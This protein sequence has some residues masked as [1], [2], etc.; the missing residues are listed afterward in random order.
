MLTLKWVYNWLSTWWTKLKFISVVC[1]GQL[2]PTELGDFLKFLVTNLLQN[3]LFELFGR[4]SSLANMKFFWQLLGI[5]WD[6]FYSNG[7]AGCGIDCF[8]SDKRLV[9]ATNNRKLQSIPS[10]LKD[11]FSD[12]WFFLFMQILTLVAPWL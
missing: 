3:W 5:I 7:H 2:W 1:C 4:T 11:P 12:K 9:C 10:V 6:T 8:H